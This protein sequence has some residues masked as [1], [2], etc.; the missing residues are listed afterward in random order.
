MI[1][2]NNLNKTF[3]NTSVIFVDSRI[4]KTNQIAKDDLVFFVDENHNISSI[5]VLD[6]NKYYISDETKFGYITSK[7]LD[8]IQQKANELNLILSNEPKFIYGLIKE[9]KA[10]P[11]SERLFVLQVHISPEKEIQLVTNTLDSQEGKVVVLALPGSVT[12]AGTDVVAGEIMGVKS[13]GMLTGYQT[14]GF[15]KEG[16]IFGD[17]SLIGKDFEFK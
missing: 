17:A 10:H 1:L 15:D 13:Y 16:L 9:R 2:F 14:L 5:N 6:N 3:T 8:L 11:K 7:T 4:K 12:K